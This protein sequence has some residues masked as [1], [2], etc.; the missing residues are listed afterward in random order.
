MIQA[1]V[2]KRLLEKLENTSYGAI[3]DIGCGSGEVFKNFEIS[4]LDYK[5]FTA[6]DSSE[7]MLA[8]HPDGADI[9]KVCGDFN[10]KDFNAMLPRK[11]YDLVLSSSALQWS[12][13]LDFTIQTIAALSSTLH[14]AIFTSNTF[15]TLHQTAKVS[16]PIY[17]AHEVQESILKYYDEASFEIHSYTLSFDSVR[18][19][20]RYIKKSGVSSGEKKLSYKE[21][22]KLMKE[23]PLGYLEFEVL[24]VEAKTM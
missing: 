22:K 12:A 16:S 5:T 2:A 9:K 21:T 11:K 19:M 4:S 18:E 24:F 1:E 23:Y 10:A 8:L 20:F 6:F 7:N 3:L 14:A 17:T 13:D 15:K